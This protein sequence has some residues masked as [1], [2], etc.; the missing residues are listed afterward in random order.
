MM[1]ALAQKY[2]NEYNAQP[3]TEKLKT[4]DLLQSLVSRG[5]DD[6]K[7]CQQKLANDVNLNT[8]GLIFWQKRLHQS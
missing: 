4:K 3:I 5:I 1:V 2:Y 8:Q 7:S 6:T